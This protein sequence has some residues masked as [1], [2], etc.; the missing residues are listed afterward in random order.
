M[1][2]L[3]VAVVVA[4][5]TWSGASFAQEPA[6]GPSAP[7]WPSCEGGVALRR[8][9]ESERNSIPTHRLDDQRARGFGIEAQR[10][11]EADPGAASADGLGVAH[12]AG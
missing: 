3:G 5:L 2:S 1:R 11:A 4:G 8:A 6:P 12:V 9:L 10:D 7:A